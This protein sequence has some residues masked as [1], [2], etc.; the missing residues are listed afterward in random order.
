M[1]TRWTV[2]V[3]SVELLATADAAMR[4]PVAAV[5]EQSPEEGSNV[6]VSQYEIPMIKPD[7]LYLPAGHFGG[8]VADVATGQTANNTRFSFTILIL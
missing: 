5:T 7:G 8:G 6:H 3:V 4:G 2:L 1:I